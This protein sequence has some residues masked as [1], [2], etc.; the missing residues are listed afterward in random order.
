M[1]V[2]VEVAGIGNLHACSAPRVAHFFAGFFEVVGMD[3]ILAAAVDQ[4]L[5]RY[6]SVASQLVIV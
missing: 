1:T 4:L 2:F 6:L 3:E 5:A